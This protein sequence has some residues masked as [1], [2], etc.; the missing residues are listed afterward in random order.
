MAKENGKK[1]RPE[2]RKVTEVKGSF[3]VNVPKK[4]VRHYGIKAGDSVALV[5]GAET[6]SILPVRGD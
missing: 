1:L 2:M 3:Q 5:P 4:F 6:I